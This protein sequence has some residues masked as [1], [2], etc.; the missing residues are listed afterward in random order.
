[1]DANALLVREWQ[2]ILESEHKSRKTITS[3]TESVRALAVFLDGADLLTVTTDYLRRFIA[4]LLATR[5]ASTA[6]TWARAPH[7]GRTIRCPH[8]AAR[9]SQ[10]GQP[11]ARA[12]QLLFFYTGLLSH[13]IP[14]RWAVCLLYRQMAP[15]CVQL[16]H[17]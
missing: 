16:G 13:P 10:I 3:Y 6:A 2:H 7:L 5:S 1:V 9:R 12:R 17:G 15:Q 11:P 4:K 8:L 14:K